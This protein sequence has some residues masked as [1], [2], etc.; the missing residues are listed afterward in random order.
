MKYLVQIETT[1]PGEWKSIKASCA[2]AA[3]FIAVRPIIKSGLNPK[4]ANVA[5]DTPENKHPN[6]A[7]IC[8]HSKVLH[9]IR[10]G[11]RQ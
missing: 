11:V 4:C 8:V 9:V 10:D 7:P 6:G 1:N 5:V 3:I 2:D